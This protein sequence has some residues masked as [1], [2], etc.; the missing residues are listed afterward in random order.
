MVGQFGTVDDRGTGRL[1]GSHQVQQLGAYGGLGVHPEA[2]PRQSKDGVLEGGAGGQKLGVAAAAAV[3]GRISALGQR[4]VVARIDAEDGVQRED[5]V[6]H[7]A[8][9]R[10]HGVLV[11]ALGHHPVGL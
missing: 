1:D 5:R 2:S 3:A 11:A 4:V 10:A 6:T 7:R 8:R 9:Q